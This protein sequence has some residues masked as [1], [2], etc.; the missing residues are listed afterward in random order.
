MTTCSY[1]FMI[2]VAIFHV[3]VSLQYEQA[4]Q[5]VNPAI[6]LPYWEYA[7]DNYLY[8][9]PGLSVVF[10]EDWFGEMTPQTETHAMND[11][12]RWSDIELRQGIFT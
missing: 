4:L 6:S 1:L 9:R 3:G 2:G 10:S 5:S 8:S 12:S 7:K 11:N